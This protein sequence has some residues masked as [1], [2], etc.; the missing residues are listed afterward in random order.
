MSKMSSKELYIDDIIVRFLKNSR[1]LT[2]LVSDLVKNAM[3]TTNIEEED[4]IRCLQRD[5]KDRLTYISS[6]LHSKGASREE[7][8]NIMDIIS[9][10]KEKTKPLSEEF[11]SISIH[12]GEIEEILRNSVCNK[13]IRLKTAYGMLRSYRRASHNLDKN[14]YS[15]D[16]FFATPEEEPQSE[17]NYREMFNDESLRKTLREKCIYLFAKHTYVYLDAIYSK[18]LDFLINHLSELFPNSE[19]TDRLSVIF[20]SDEEGGTTTKYASTKQIDQIWRIV[21][22]CVKNS[23]IYCKLCGVEHFDVKILNSSG[24]KVLTRYNI[25]YAREKERWNLNFEEF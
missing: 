14:G 16:L 7:I 17:K 18:N 12:E 19:F 3:E 8:I 13:C 21:Q 24:E 5:L 1:N 22:G 20:A 11:S 15:W 25:N 23:L 9:G 2:D 6:E 4:E 10:E